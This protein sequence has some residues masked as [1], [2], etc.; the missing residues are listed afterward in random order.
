MNNNMQVGSIT[1]NRKNQFGS[2]FPFDVKVDG[3]F[4]GQ[5]MNGES[6]TFPIYYGQHYLLIE[7]SYD[8]ASQA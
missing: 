3:Y 8:S 5:V 6:K 4:I 2:I 1:I 7:H